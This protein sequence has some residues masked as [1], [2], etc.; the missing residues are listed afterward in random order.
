MVVE[1]RV[2]W[3]SRNILRKAT[4]GQL[5]RLAEEQF[6][7]LF[8]WW[9]SSPKVEF[10]EDQGLLR[11][12]TG[13]KMSLY[14]CVGRA[15]LSEREAD[16]AIDDVLQ[17]SRARGLPRIWLLDSSTRPKDL[18]ERLVKHGFTKE[19]DTPGM[20][21]DLQRMRDDPPETPGLEIKEVRTRKQQEVFMDT[22]VR[23]YEMPLEDTPKVTEVDAG[24]CFCKDNQCRRYYALLEGEPVATSLMFPSRG[25]AGVYCVATIKD[26]RRKG[27]GTQITLAPLRDAKSMG[28]KYGVLQATRAGHPVYSKIGFEDQGNVRMYYFN[29]KPEKKV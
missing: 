14:N 19:D 13:T 1:K 11:L 5:G 24:L 8:R 3:R 29:P 10:H 15:R 22:M 28:F 4:P 26:H 12:I 9:G 27:I 21:V 7:D 18:P 2:D 6:Y 17:E 25:V 16:D 23:A 20:S